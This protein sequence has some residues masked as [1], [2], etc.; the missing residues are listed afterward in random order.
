VTR[1]T[2][3]FLAVT[4]FV[5][6]LGVTAAVARYRE[7]PR[8]IVTP[9][10]VKATGAPV[11]VELFTSEGCSS[12][13]PADNLLQKLAGEQ[14]VAG[15]HVIALGQHVDYWNRLGWADPFSSRQFSERQDAYRRAFGSDSVYT[16][17]MVVDGRTEFV[18][19]NAG[20]AKSAIA[21]AAR[22][23][24][25]AQITLSTAGAN[26]KVQV[27]ALPTGTLTAGEA[28]D[29]YVAVTEDG[30]AS[31]V[32]RGE[33]AGRRLI[34]AAVT[35]RLERVGTLKPGVPF[36]ATAPLHLE[37]GWKRERLYMVAFVQERNGR[38]IL[39]A[40]EA[41]LQEEVPA[42]RG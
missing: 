9:T 13:P 21:D 19:S 7:E 38:H 4:A 5:G 2:P 40:T 23:P 42:P 22:Q 1:P 39:G 12:C 3:L 18:G 32:A 14:P 29:V 26:G 33:N 37:N 34:H 16:P 30:L 41:K 25:P 11:L 31:Q 17:Q 36:T 28:A 10:R 8:G 15:A 20:R 6:T 27:G 35:R 24:K